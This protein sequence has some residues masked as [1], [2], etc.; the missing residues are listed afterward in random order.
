MNSIKIGTAINS[1]VVGTVTGG[2]LITGSSVNEQRQTL[3]AL[4]AQLSTEANRA[5]QSLPVED[6]QELAT[7]IEELS[8]QTNSPSPDKARIFNLLS[9]I[10]DRTKAAT[11]LA[12]PIVDLLKNIADVVAKLTI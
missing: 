3:A 2:T 1:N 8:H 9:T 6:A 5:V 7:S 11:Q 4:I 12:A 10:A